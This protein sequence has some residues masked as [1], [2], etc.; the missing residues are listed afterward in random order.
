[1]ISC[2]DAIKE[3]YCNRAGFQLHLLGDD[4]SACTIFEMKADPRSKSGT[5]LFPNFSCET[6]SWMK[7]LYLSV[8]LALWGIYASNAANTGNRGRIK[9]RTAVATSF[10]NT[11][12]QD[13]VACQRGIVNSQGQTLDEFLLALKEKYS[14]EI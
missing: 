13:G 4:A 2:N 9:C 7:G 10:S 1:M 14:A 6:A 12:L 5:P 8:G 3:N 11:H